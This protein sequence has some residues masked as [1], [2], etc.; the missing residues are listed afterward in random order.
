MTTEN[1]REPN[2]QVSDQHAENASWIRR[3]PDFF[4]PVGKVVSP[5]AALVTIVVGIGAFLGVHFASSAN[6]RTT[7]GPEKVVERYYTAINR[8]AWLEAWVLGGK[9]LGHGPYK[10]LSGM[11]SGYR[12]TSRDTIKDLSSNG[13]TVSG[14]LVAND[15]YRGIR[16][17]QTYQFRYIV[18][19][20]AIR[21]AHVVLMT[22][23]APPGCASN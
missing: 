12:C 9:Y 13:N 14:Y 11:I 6:S 18:W 20:G 23:R 22:G 2:A 16:T 4:D 17:K 5:I 21:K 10:T 7:T 15:F 3:I 8:H 19:G 1:A